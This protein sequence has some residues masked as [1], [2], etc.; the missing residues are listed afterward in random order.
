MAKKLNR[1]Q[2]LIEHIFFAHYKEGK[3]EFQFLREELH[4]GAAALGFADIKNIG[5]VPY[6]FRY[7]NQLPN[8]IINTQP[9]GLEWIIVGA[10]KGIYRF[11]GTSKNAFPRCR[12]GKM[13][14]T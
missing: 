13:G 14:V 2:A 6:S 9:K 1:Y 8:R 10:G 3:T 7:R 5:D 4:S 12:P 11:K